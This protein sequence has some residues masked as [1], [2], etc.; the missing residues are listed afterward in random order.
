MSPTAFRHSPLL[1]AA[2]A[3]ALVVGI[4][5]P[6]HAQSASQR[7]AERRASQEARAEKPATSESAQARYA[8]ATREQPE[9]KASARLSRRLE[10]MMGHYDE[11]ESAEARAIADE[12]I[13]NEKANAYEKSFAAQIAAQIAYGADDTA[14]AMRYLQQALEFN[15]LDNTGH[16]DSML[17]LAQLQLQE[18][19]YAES[20]VTFDRF[21][22]ESKSQQPEHLVLKGNALYRMERFPEAIAVLEQA[23]AATPEPRA[24]WLQL[25]MGAYA[26]TNQADKAAQL[27]QQLASKNPGDK[28]AQMNLAAIYVQGDM[29][30]KAAEVLEGLRASGQFTESRDYQQLYSTYLNLEGNEKKAAEVINEGIQKGILEPDFQAYLALAQALYFSEQID[31]AIDAYK[32]AAPLDTDGDTYLNLARVLWQEDRIPEAK[33]AARQAIAKGVQEPKDANTIIALPGG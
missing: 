5:G 15:G 2:I 27:A 28:R 33:E 20:L 24:D 8:Q 22:A 10:A 6:S 19:Q 12:I 4:A 29:L 9:A 21:L 1:T 16:F 31:P 3:A 17:M 23:I 7:A 13:A 11:D 32:K 26:E 18:E 25:L 14:T 30:D